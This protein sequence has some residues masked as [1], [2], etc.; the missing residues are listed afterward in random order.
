MFLPGGSAPPV[1]AE[2]TGN[3]K[4]K[5]GTGLSRIRGDPREG[6]HAVEAARIAVNA[7]EAVGEDAAAEEAPELAL[8]EAG[9]G[10]SR[11]CARARKLPSSLWTTP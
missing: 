8:D 1:Y 6:D 9:T 10:L 3:W 11:A 7:H 4:T 2:G 5:R